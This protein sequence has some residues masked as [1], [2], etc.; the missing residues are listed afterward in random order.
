MVKASWLLTDTMVCLLST[1]HIFTPAIRRKKGKKKKLIFTLW[2]SDKRRPT[3]SHITISD[4]FF[5]ST[6]KILPRGWIH[7][8]IYGIK[9]V[10]SQ[11]IGASKSFF[12]IERVFWAIYSWFKN[13]LLNSLLP[14]SHIIFMWMRKKPKKG[15][16]EKLTYKYNLQSKHVLGFLSP[17]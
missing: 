12:N 9:S 2:F 11:P 5:Y 3:Q 13:P 6:D 17:V 1:E 15:K 16:K 10:Q 8:L 14:F 7:L 4:D